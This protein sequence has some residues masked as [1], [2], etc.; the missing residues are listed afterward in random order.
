M[1]DNPLVTK[2]YPEEGYSRDDAAQA[3]L[4]ARARWKRKQYIGC[5]IGVGIGTGLMILGGYLVRTEFTETGWGVF[6]IASVYAL[7]LGVMHPKRVCL[8]CG[9]EFEKRWVKG[10]GEMEDLFL[11]C[12]SCGKYVF[13]HEVRS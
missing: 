5:A 11:V 2:E 3:L 7:V 8:S 4:D 12:D 13:A 10:E 6:F 9:R 1:R